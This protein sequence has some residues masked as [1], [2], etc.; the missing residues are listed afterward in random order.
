MQRIIL[1]AALVAASVVTAKAETVWVGNAFVD[2]VSGP[3]S[4]TS[5]FAVGDFF[6]LIYRPRGGPLGNGTIGFLAAV[7]P[8]SSIVMSVVDD[9]QA[10]VDYNGLSVSSTVT[11]KTNTASIAAWQQN[12]ATLAATTPTVKITGRFANFFRI[13]DCLVQLRGNLVKR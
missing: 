8:R 11:I 3:E 9:F 10:G 7:N 6:R 2:F 5:A 12:P 4:C 13:R 1:A